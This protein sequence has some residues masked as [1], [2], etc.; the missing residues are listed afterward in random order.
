[1]TTY[2]SKEKN[3]QNS[4][5]KV[6]TLFLTGVLFLS[7]FVNA[8]THS[9]SNL[10][11]N[12]TET[13]AVNGFS[14][15]HSSNPI[16]IV[17][18]INASF[19]TTQVPYLWFAANMNTES[20]YV[21]ISGNS[22]TNDYWEL[23]AL[24]IY[25]AYDRCLTA[26]FYVQYGISSQCTNPSL[27]SSILFSIDFR[28]SNGESHLDEDLTLMI[29]ISDIDDL[30]S[31][32]SETYPY[33]D[34]NINQDS[35]NSIKPLI[36]L[37]SGVSGANIQGFFEDQYDYDYLRFETPFKGTHLLNLTFDRDITIQPYSYNG[38]LSNCERTDNTGFSNV[39]DIYSGYSGSSPSSLTA[40]GNTLYFEAN[41]GN[42][43]YELWKTDGT[44]AGTSMVKDINN[45]YSS[46]S[47]SYL[48]AVGNTLYFKATD[49]INGNELWKTDGTE[50][51]TMVKDIN[52]GGSGGN[53]YSLTAVGNT[54]Y[55]VADNGNK[56]NELWKTDGTEAGTS[57]VKDIYSGY[58]SS[59]PSSLTAVGN[60]LYF[61]ATDGNNGYELW[62]TDGTEAGTS[63]VR[64]IYSGSSS[65]G[66]TEITSFNGKLYFNA[67]NGYVGNELFSLIETAVTTY[68]RFYECLVIP[69]SDT[70]D[71]QFDLTADVDNSLYPYSWNA[72]I[73]FEQIHVLEDPNSGDSDG[74]SYTPT[75]LPSTSSK[76]GVYN[77]VG[78]KDKYAI[79]VDHG[80][81]QEIEIKTS[82]SAQVLIN[83]LNCFTQTQ[84]SVSQITLSSGEEWNVFVCDTKYNADEIVFS[85]AEINDGTRTSLYPGYEMR[86]ST[87]SNSNVSLDTPLEMG[88]EDI[89]KRGM[90]PNLNVLEKV[91]G[92]FHYWSDQTD[93]YALTLEP[94]ESIQ[95]NLSSNCASF[96]SNGWT[97]PSYAES[98][99]IT[100]GGLLEGYG[101]FVSQNGLQEMHHVPV[102]RSSSN[103]VYDVELKDICTYKI[104]SNPITTVGVLSNAQISYD[105]R[106]GDSSDLVINNFTDYLPLH[107]TANGYTITVPLDILPTK[108]GYLEATQAS[109]EP[110]S[111]LLRGTDFPNS[112]LNKITVGQHIDFGSPR[113]QWN[114][115]RVS[116]LDGS[117]LTV[118]FVEKPITLHTKESSELYS[119]ATGSLGPSHDE[120]WDGSD[121][122][123]FNNT[124]SSSTFASVRITSLSDTLKASF[125]GGKM[126]SFV[127]FN[128]FYTPSVSVYHDS[129]N[130]AYTMQ[131]N[132]GMGTCPS[133]SVTSPS[134]VPSASNF[135][136]SYTTNSLDLKL[137]LM[138]FNENFE[139]V[140]TSSNTN[141]TQLVTLPEL[142]EGRYLML[143]MDDQGIT[144]HE[145]SLFIT[146]Q[147]NRLVQTTSSYL[148]VNEALKIRVYPFMPHTGEP[149]AWEFTNITLETLSLSGEKIEQLL[150]DD[151]SGLGAEVITLDEIPEVMPGSMIKITG[152]LY[153]NNVYSIHTLVWKVAYIAPDIEC[154][155]AI[156]PDIRSAENDLLCLISMDL[157]THGYS[158]A[159]RTSNQKFEGTLDVYSEDFSLINQIEFASSLFD[160]TIVRIN[161]VEMK[162]GTY[163]VKTNFSTANNMYFQEEVGEFVV[164]PKLLFELDEAEI[165]SFDLT[166][167]SVRD[168]AAAGDD[169]V[170]AWNT[171]GE[172]AAYFVAE[173]YSN[174]V[175]V[176]SF[177]IIND[178]ETN[179]K[180]EFEL[181]D[182]SNPY[183]DHEIRIYAYSEYGLTSIG[184]SN[185]EGVNKQS[186]LDVNINPDR[187]QIGSEI[188][189]ELMLSEDGNW[190]SWNW[191]LTKGSSINSGIIAQGDGFEESDRIDFDF[192]LPL[193]QYTSPP[194]LHLT[195][196]GGDGTI[197]QETIKI[198]PV[199]LRS[200][201]IVMDSE[202]VMDETYE[203]EW[204]VSG[205]YLNTVD[206]I[207]RIEFSIL[208]MDYETYKEEVYFVDSDSG[209]FETNIPSTLNPGS[210][211]VVIEF[212]FSDGE[213]FEHTQI[214]TV[215]SSPPGITFLGITIP[216]LALGFDTILV[217]LLI[218]HAIF[219]HR[220]NSE[221]RDEGKDDAFED[222]LVTT[223]LEHQSPSEED[224]EFSNSQQ[225]MTA[226]SLY[227]GAVQGNDYLQTHESDFD[228]SDEYPIYQ[229]HPINS[230]RYWVM[231]AP[232]EEWALVEDDF[233]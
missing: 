28:D 92:T 59:S 186:Y 143:L 134:M 50:S 88:M 10:A 192:E 208:T 9:P 32:E 178:G 1:M 14:G 174:D 190:M 176:D 13:R 226:A 163:F 185:I 146:N 169:I 112:E 135:Q 141:S 122:F 58:S 198:E 149:L 20:I 47:P 31:D 188:N 43:G 223:N 74:E 100:Y 55:F 167:I 137:N 219:L 23:G 24:N 29:T 44:E 12:S 125:S 124:D 182:N 85:I 39:K 36:E 111:L 4:S 94:G 230:G 147:P 216:P 201:N 121:T 179:G 105:G 110:V 34:G 212:T 41:N 68:K 202:M 120:G 181:P 154:E 158:L 173:I 151:F 231:H 107:T 187:P 38:A 166:I 104:Q 62:K 115:L 127:C 6:R 225:G 180:F 75:L 11:E 229:E 56:G 227:G 145:K 97:K 81:L 170:L 232:D 204:E 77:S 183:L 21:N 196:E 224:F 49:G 27:D 152:E 61:K 90:L 206:N 101:T 2:P 109:N 221:K 15:T 172:K 51:G 106:M 200:V 233:D 79:Q 93:T 65:S 42:N 150:E 66:V 16:P 57:M 78:D 46:S 159:D 161:T 139:S 73:N 165:G 138:I 153:I 25:T 217:F 195:V 215:L 116:G 89:P 211:R 80:T 96:Y 133:I 194:Y 214:I 228:G 136:I 18:T 210:H 108:E 35:T 157:E 184:T 63:L 114:E 156:T 72:D 17:G 76:T 222:L 60:T 171:E 189:V 119:I 103:S 22:S 33:S 123:E 98:K 53:P 209:E 70:F 52:N 95:L 199:P 175:L 19:E 205:Q 48:T 40:V 86:L 130:G 117:E 218:A 193:S 69:S 91:N 45:G 177:S 3:L 148:D 191:K 164:N 5:S 87:V 118:K 220:R 140:Y 71:I 82:T 8:F 67:D 99:I 102:Y 131:V 162:N 126:T 54:L 160:E 26:Q 142:E 213:T 113:V 37:G 207:E 168:T 84:T 83:S 129:G 155:S 64:D 7:L 128:E 144:Y 30:V 203:V 132:R 197:Y